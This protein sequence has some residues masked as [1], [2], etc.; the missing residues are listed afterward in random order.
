V[1]S[2]HPRATVARAAVTSFLAARG[3][4]WCFKEAPYRSVSRKAH[5]RDLWKK[6]TSSVATT[7]RRSMARGVGDVSA[8]TWLSG[9]PEARRRPRVAS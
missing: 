4:W 3:T 1:R 2:S 5:R 6:I 8:K 7:A 9:K